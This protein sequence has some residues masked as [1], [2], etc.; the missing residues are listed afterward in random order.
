MSAA[1]TPSPALFFETVNAYHRTEA[2][3]T[4]IELELFTHVAAGKTTVE[5]LADACRASPRGIRILADFLTILGFLHKQGDEYGLTPD[6]AVFLDRR[7]PAYLGGSLEFFLSPGIRE[8]F[9]QLTAAVRRGGTAIS[10]EGT[11][12]HDNPIWVAFARGMAPLMQLPARLFTD[13]IGGDTQQPLRVLDVAAGHGI[14]GITVAERYPQACI[15]ALD[16]PNVL[17][18]ATE[19]AQKRGVAARH[20]LLPGSAFETDWGGPYDLILLTNFLHHFDEPTCRQLAEK[21]HAALAP[22]GRVITLEFIP[23]PDRVSPPATATFALVMLATTARG[24]AY[25][26]AEYQ[27]IFAAAGFRRSEFR[28]LPPTAQQAV[29]SY[30]G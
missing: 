5:P 4:A 20:S 22:G 17:A 12:S 13:L 16:W 3:R 30:K 15:T 19:N 10:E 11:V 8:P 24:D 6:A 18:V 25:T 2:L 23:E 7:S 29:V 26:F 27:E 28:A 9:A 14:F 1:S 21:C